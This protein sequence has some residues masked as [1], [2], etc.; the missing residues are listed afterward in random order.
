MFLSKRI[1]GKF[2]SPMIEAYK[3]SIVVK[4][5]INRSIPSLSSIFMVKKRD[6]LLVIDHMQ[7]TIKKKTQGTFTSHHIST[8]VR[9]MDL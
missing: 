7:L 5:T 8:Y 1:S 9:A 2:F 4:N 6:E 3:N